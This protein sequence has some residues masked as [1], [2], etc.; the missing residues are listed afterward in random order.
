MAGFSICELYTAFWICQNMLW[1]SSEYILNSKYVR[2]LNMSEFW[3]WQVS[4]A[5]YSRFWICYN[6]AEYVS[7]LVNMPEYV[8]IYDNRQDSEYAPY[9][10]WV[11]VTLKVNQYLLRDRHIQNPVKT[12]MERF[13][14]ITFVNFFC[15]K[16]KLKSWEGS[17]YV[18][19][20]KYV[21]VVNIRKFS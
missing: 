13:G 17:K 7:I 9:S 3:L 4:D 16:L 19:G 21:R 8:W 20:F 10:A 5:S 12:K 1:Q 11:E 6:M 15:K 14:K 18:F 2:I